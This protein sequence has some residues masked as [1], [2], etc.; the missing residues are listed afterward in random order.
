M[1]A[2]SR[3]VCVCVRTC[4]CKQAC[5]HMRHTPWGGTGRRKLSPES[6]P[7]EEDSPSSRYPLDELPC[8]QGLAVPF[9]WAG[10]AWKE[11]LR[12]GW[13]EPCPSQV[14]G[15][16]RT[17]RGRERESGLSAEDRAES[18]GKPAQVIKCGALGTGAGPFLFFSF[19]FPF[20]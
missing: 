10:A 20:C 16:L 2:C 18:G 14:Q 8:C 17:S 12:G 1:P 15:Q 11:R 19:L 4:A 13:Q 3:V 6:G 9:R 7:L 5:I